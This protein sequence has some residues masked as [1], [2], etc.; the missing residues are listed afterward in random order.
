MPSVFPHERLDVYQLY[1]AV[2]GQCRELVVQT[3]ASIVAIDHLERALES[4]GVNLMRANSQP[5]GSAQ[6][7][8]TAAGT[9]SANPET[10]F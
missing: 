2:T 10:P 7:L 6:R 5:T 4:I 1:L 9:H 8:P 3:P